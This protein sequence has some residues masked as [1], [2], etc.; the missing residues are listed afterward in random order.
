M[1]ETDIKKR[2]FNSEMK[3]TGRYTIHPQSIAIIPATAQ[4][5]VLL[6][7]RDKYWQLGGDHF[8][9]SGS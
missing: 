6:Q 5:G 7:F 9:P 4:F 1:K 8:F 3:K 2:K